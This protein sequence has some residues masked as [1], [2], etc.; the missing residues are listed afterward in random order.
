MIGHV[1]DN[2]TSMFPCCMK[3]SNTFSFCLEYVA[4][5]TGTVRIGSTI[6]HRPSEH[7]DVPIS[8]TQACHS[9]QINSIQGVSLEVRVVV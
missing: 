2:R 6:S 1:H 8:N 7:T 4:V 3:K 5:T 9:N